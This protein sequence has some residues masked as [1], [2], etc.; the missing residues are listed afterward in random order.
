[1]TIARTLS[2][3]ALLGASSLAG[4]ATTTRIYVE[5]RKETNGGEPLYMV[6]RSSDGKSFVTERYQDAAAKLFTRGQDP[7]VIAQEPIFP[8]RPFTLTI[9]DADK[10]DLVV[11]FFFT[12]PG[13][14]WRVPLRRPLP[15]E[16]AIDL[17]A[18]DIQKVQVRKR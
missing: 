18:N 4:C 8:G 10:K 12:K 6:V 9:E 13:N 7:D 17:G 1:M 11:Y 5:S 3:F 2:F 14:N 16:A 15:A